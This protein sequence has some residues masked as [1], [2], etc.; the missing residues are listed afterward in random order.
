MVGA[1]RQR[2]C[3]GGPCVVRSAVVHSAVA[4]QRVITASGLNAKR[5]TVDRRP[6]HGHRLVGVGQRRA[7]NDTARELLTGIRNLNA[8]RGDI[9]LQRERVDGSRGVLNHEISAAIETGRERR[10]Q[11]I[12]IFQTLNHGPQIL[13]LPRSVRC[14]NP[15]PRTGRRAEA[16][17]ENA[18]HGQTP[19]GQSLNQSFKPTT[20]EHDHTSGGGEGVR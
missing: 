10:R 2:R 16:A 20:N 6:Q 7:G 1:D 4:R 8:V 13:R 3:D 18:A 15:R 12:P 5:R 17:R 19:R 9:E 11:Q 14:N